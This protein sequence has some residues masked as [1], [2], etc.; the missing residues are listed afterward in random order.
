MPAPCTSSTA[1]HTESSVATAALWG[2]RTWS[3]QL[4]QVRSVQSSVTM[5]GVWP[6]IFPMSKNVRDVPPL[7]P[8]GRSSLPQKARHRLGVPAYSSFRTL[9]AIV[10]S[11]RTCQ[12]RNTTPMPPSAS[13]PSDAIAPRNQA[14]SVG[15]LSHSV[16]D[17]VAPGT[18]DPRAATEQ[19]ACRQLA[20]AGAPGFGSALLDRQVEGVASACDQH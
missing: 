13:G 8:R 10:C 15:S 18:R 17:V 9:I 7:Q 16:S 11:S 1:S 5:N 12:P 4:A 3:Q 14:G 6:L 2:E 20:S 19:V